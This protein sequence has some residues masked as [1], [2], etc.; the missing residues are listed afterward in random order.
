M[1]TTAKANLPVARYLAQ[2]HERGL[3]LNGRLLVVSIAEQKLA[4]FASSQAPRIYT[5]STS[6]WGV[7]PKANSYK[8]P[9]GW[10]RITAWI[11]GRARPGQVF[12]A[13]RPTREVVPP[14]MWRSTL[15]KDYVLTRILRLDGMEAGVNRGAGIDTHD[16]FIYLHGTNEEHLLGQPA[17]QG[18]IRLSNRDIMELFDLTNDYQTYCWIIEQPLGLE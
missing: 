11:G 15:P 4:L 2:A 3:A 6:K 10:H 1:I 5:V 7:G 18:C 12:V 8:T 9:T 17:S 14:E 13:R 16:R